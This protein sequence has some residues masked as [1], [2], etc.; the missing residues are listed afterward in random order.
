LEAEQAKSLEVE[1]EEEE[2]IRVMR[3]SMK[4]ERAVF[5]AQLAEERMAFQEE[6]RKLEAEQTKLLE[7][8]VEAGAY[9]RS[10]SSST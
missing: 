9:T 3:Q 4:A 1:V 7:E 5:D 6:Q 8:E 2:E 10:L